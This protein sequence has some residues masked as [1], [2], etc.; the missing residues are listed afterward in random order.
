MN[1]YTWLVKHMD[2][3]QDETLRQTYQQIVNTH[4]T[5]QKALDIGCGTGYMTHV[6]K[7]FDSLKAFDM[8][9]AMVDLTKQRFE[10]ADVFVHDMKTPLNETFDVIMASTDV[11]NHITSYH[12]FKQTLSMWFDHVKAG[13]MLVFDL[14]NPA[15]VQAITG[16][17][18]RLDQTMMWTV[19]PTG[20]PLVINHVL[21]DGN[22]KHAHRERAYHNDEIKEALSF[23][24]HI[25]MVEYP[26]RTI[27]I[28]KK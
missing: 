24:H 12:A 27:Y 16:H 22:T 28:V 25:E 21:D 9:Q 4:P 20:N 19:E 1:T 17:Q 14:L 7:D 6:L 13:G 18:E 11:F 2:A 10:Q 3:Q 5:K 26:E 15:Y 23:A 8:N